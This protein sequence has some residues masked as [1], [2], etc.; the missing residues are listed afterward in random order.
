MTERLTWQVTVMPAAEK[1]LKRLPPQGQA[2]VRAAIEGLRSGPPYG[3]LR[4]L[5]GRENE[6]RLRVGDWRIRLR[7]DLRTRVIVILHVLPRES[8]YRD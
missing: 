3:H 8:A 7:P 5:K 6:W 1:E 2:R 4:K